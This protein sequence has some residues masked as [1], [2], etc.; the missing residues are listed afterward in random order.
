[1]DLPELLQET[2]HRRDGA[3][4]EPG[5]AG[6]LQDGDR[7]RLGEV[8][9]DRLPERGRMQRS[10]AAGGLG[11]TERTRAGEYLEIQGGP[12]VP[13]DEVDRVLGNVVQPT[14][15]GL[16]DRAEVAGGMGH[17]RQLDE[18][19]AR[20]VCPGRRALNKPPVLERGQQ[21]KRCRLWYACPQRYLP[22]RRRAI[23]GER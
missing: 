18:P 13:D 20:L 6:F 22:E 11:K 10:G 12:I 3:G 9:G 15:V 21:A 7:F 23:V 19:Q 5:E 14:E 2:R 4:C 16:G 8:R 1:A 17:L